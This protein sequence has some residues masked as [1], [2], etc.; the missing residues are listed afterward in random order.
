MMMKRV[1]DETRGK[2]GEESLLKKK[3]GEGEENFWWIF[4][5][6]LY[7]S[8]FSGRRKRKEFEKLLKSCL[9]ALLLK[10]FF[11]MS[12]LCIPIIITFS[13]ASFQ[14]REK[15]ERKKER[16]ERKWREFNLKLIFFWKERIVLYHHYYFE[17]YPPI[18]GEKGKMSEGKGEGEGE[19]NERERK[20]REKWADKKVALHSILMRKK[21]RKWSRSIQGEK[22]IFPPLFLSI[23]NDGES[24]RLSL[25]FSFSLLLSF[26]SLDFDYV[27]LV[28][29][30]VYKHRQST[31]FFSRDNER[32]CVCEREERERVNEWDI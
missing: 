23:Q 19:K 26:L 17:G 11:C 9:F 18:P 24:N 2:R 5:F 6:T 8:S 3:R 4:P 31:N 25:F 16:E 22:N 14:T 28:C 1:D 32:V 12:L 20:K 30:C 29:C 7:P 15:R 27:Y 10:K 21:G 13:L